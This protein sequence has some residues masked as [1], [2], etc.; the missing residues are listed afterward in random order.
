MN[1]GDK[2]FSSSTDPNQFSSKIYSQ[3]KKYFTAISGSEGGIWG[4]YDSYG[5]RITSI[6]DSI[7]DVKYQ[8]GALC[9]YSGKT[10]LVKTNTKIDGKALLLMNNN[11]ILQL[12]DTSSREQWNSNTK[13]T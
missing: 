6:A 5:N 8:S 4:I 7:D 2:L 3:D 12:L 9:V 10:L 1:E 11:G 13:L